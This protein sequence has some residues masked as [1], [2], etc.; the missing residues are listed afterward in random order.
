MDNSLLLIITHAHTYRGINRGF[1]IH[2]IHSAHK[3]VHINMLS[4][5]VG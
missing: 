2:S 3:V 4:V 5:Y 1:C